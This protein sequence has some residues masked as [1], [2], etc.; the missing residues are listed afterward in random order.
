MTNIFCSKNINYLTNVAEKNSNQQQVVGIFSRKGQEKV[1]IGTTGINCSVDD[2][3]EP[4][5][6]KL[7]I[8]SRKF[9]YEKA[10][11]I[12]KK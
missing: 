3:W 7:L 10:E 5:A 4:G 1:K 12:K 2:F 9:Y 11:A 8:L 6:E